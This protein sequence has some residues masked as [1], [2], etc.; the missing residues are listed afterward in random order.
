M[1]FMFGANERHRVRNKTFPFLELRASASPVILRGEFNSKGPRPHAFSVMIRLRGPFGSNVSSRF[2]SAAT[3]V[4]RVGVR[5]VITRSPTAS[6]RATRL[7]GLRNIPRRIACS[8]NGARTICRRA[9]LERPFCG[10]RLGTHKVQTRVLH[11][12]SFVGRHICVRFSV[13]VFRDVYLGLQVIRRIVSRLRRQILIVVGLLRGDRANFSIRVVRFN[14]R[15]Y[16]T[17][18]NVREDAGFIDRV[19]SRDVL[20]L[21]KFFNGL[22]STLRHLRPFTLTS[23]GSCRSSRGR[24]SGC[25]GAVC[26]YFVVL[27]RIVHPGVM[28]YHGYRCRHFLLTC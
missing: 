27:V 7:H 24:G 4:Y 17:C 15:D 28:Y 25:P 12:A 1:L 8:L 26:R 6:F 16:G 18:G 20:R 11:H 5:I 2:V 13:I 9:T 23:K 3:Y 21:I 22:V 10:L 19:D 14:G